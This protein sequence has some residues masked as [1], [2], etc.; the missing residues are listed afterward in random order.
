[1][2]EQL[3]TTRGRIVRMTAGFYYLDTPD[4]EV[5]C[6][7]RGL[8]RKSGLSPKVGDMAL[9]RLSDDG[10][11]YIVE[12]EQRK[13]ELIRPPVANL[14]LLLLVCSVVDPAPNLTVIDRLLAVCAHKGIEA[15]LVFTKA[16]LGD[17]APLERIYGKAGYKTASVDSLSGDVAAVARLITGRFCAMM[18][19]SGVGKSTLLN[20]L[21]PELS[22]KTGETSKK[23]GRGRHTTRVTEVFEAA[24]GLIADTP[25]FSSLDTIKYERIK[26]EEMADCFLE[27][28]S[29]YGS[30]RFDDCTHTS[31]RGCAIIEAVNAGEIA[32]SRH[33]S[34]LAMYDEAKQL[35]SW[36]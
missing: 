1:M 26:K 29:Y 4:G 6:R 21:R 18:G 17:T 10:S 11:G 32:P 28:S 27:F 35:N 2:V 13:N 33:K 8:F 22:L 15:A 23:L 34:Y 12:I 3:N 19:N 31:E 25:G 7:A 9:A 24:G 20:A 36:E 5:A 14:D 16:D 30:C